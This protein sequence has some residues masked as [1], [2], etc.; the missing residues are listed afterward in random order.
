MDGYNHY[1]RVDQYGNVIRAF[2]D[3]F[4][5]PQ[6]GDLLV[7][8]NSDRHFNPNL[9][10]NG[11]I[12]RWYAKRGGMLERTE[13]ELLELWEQYQV[14]HPVE[15]TEVEQLQM[16]NAGI[17]LELAQTQAR[18]D[19]TEQDQAALLLSLVMGGVL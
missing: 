17:L 16:D 8:E 18:Q 9:W 6:E 10:Y 4:E 3:A 19:Q 2:S 1:I 5:K 14:A 11:V 15:L 7:T 12:P 13:A